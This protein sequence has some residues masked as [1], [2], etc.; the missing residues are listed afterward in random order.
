MNE[1]KK[2]ENNTYRSNNIQNCIIMNG[3]NRLLTGMI[4]EQH[5]LQ[6]SAAFYL[7]LYNEVEEEVE[8]DREVFWN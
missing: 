8:R 6:Q 1:R 5:I 2:K 7:S 4:N 3:M